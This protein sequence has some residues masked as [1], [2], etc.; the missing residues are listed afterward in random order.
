[1]T[2]QPQSYPGDD[3]IPNPVMIYNQTKTLHATRSEIW[4]WL[5][6]LGKGQA[7]WYC[8]YYVEAWLPKSWAA[9]RTI[10]PE[11]QN[12]A[13]G[14]RV[15]DY[16]FSK[17][18]CFDA[19]VVEFDKALVYRSERYGCLFTWALLLR[20]ED[21]DDVVGAKPLTTVHLRFR[22]RIAATGLKRKVI[23]W[24]GGVM[25]YISTAPMLAGLAERVER[26]HRQ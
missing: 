16:G 21:V 20:A 15:P 18:D 1:M 5:L 2:H 6:Q 24:F 17:D 4:P 11:W 26:P 19:A 13:V 3:L 8:P 7:G 25:D 14:D 23:V 10:N 22:G 12:L 9:S